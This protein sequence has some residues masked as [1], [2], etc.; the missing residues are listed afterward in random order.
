MANRVKG[1]R[2]AIGGLTLSDRERQL[3]DR[4]IR[5]L[6]PQP[7]RAEFIRAAAVA[8]AKAELERSAV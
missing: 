3:I 2:K 8:R 6:E 5:H 4:A 1:G 7:S